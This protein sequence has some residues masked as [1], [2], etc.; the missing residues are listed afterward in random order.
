METRVREEGPCH[1]VAIV[2]SADVNASAALRESLLGAVE[3]G[4][5]R[6]VC[7]LSETDFICSDALGVLL[8]SPGPPSGVCAAGAGNDSPRPPL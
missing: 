8:R 6:I 4:K 7:D 2:G 3:A 5:T 1:V